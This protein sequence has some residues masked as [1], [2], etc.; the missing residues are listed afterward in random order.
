[1]RN[2]V[3]W[4]R[5]KGK[6]YQ[7]LKTY[8]KQLSIAGVAILSLTEIGCS[9]NAMTDVSGTDNTDDISEDTPSFNSSPITNTSIDPRL[10]RANT[11]FAFKLFSQI[12]REQGEE[13]IFISPASIAFAL[14][15]TYNGASGETQT[16]MAQTLELQDMSLEDV[17][18]AY[19][20]LKSTLE[21]IDPNV[22]LAIANA[23]WSNLGVDFNPD[24]LTQTREFYEAEVTELDFS[25]PNAP[26]T[27]NNWVQQKTNGKIDGIVDRIS[28]DTILFLINA[29]YFK[30]NWSEPFDAAATTEQPFTALDGSQNSHPLMSQTG[31]YQYLE[32]ETFQAVSLPYGNG[33]FSFYIFLPKENVSFSQWV[34]SVNSENWNNWI[35]QLSLKPGSIQ[36]PKFDLEYEITLNDALKALGMEISFDR[37][38]ADFSQ[39][40]VPPPNLAIDRVKHK[41][42]VEV[43][44]EG[45]EAAATTSV[46][47][48]AT[49]AR[50]IE[51]PFN[52]RVDR[53]FFCAIRENRTETIVFMGSIID[54]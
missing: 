15:M 2:R 13:N 27:I 7:S 14:A 1:M 33:Q 34:E 29:I 48:V 47:V 6:F 5:I 25:Q 17:N 28:P 38:R 11:E 44:E 19:G 36:I 21:N 10:T 12:Y 3:V 37:D 50:E 43:N 30:G 39:M 41:T 20:S 54:P 31:E 22:E 8:L 32:N 42:F 26:A 23:L 9:E 35:N 24:F 40:K 52:M 49:S 45:T 53:P 16:A 18:N 46:G 51:E 4:N